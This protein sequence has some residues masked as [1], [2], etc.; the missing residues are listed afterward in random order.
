M[1][2][3][4][5]NCRF[6]K[7]EKHMGSIQ[8]FYR[9]YSRARTPG[10]RKRSMLHRPTSRVSCFVSARAMVSSARDWSANF[11]SALSAVSWAPRPGR[12]HL[13]CFKVFCIELRLVLR[14]LLV[15][16]WP[17]AVLTSTWPHGCPTHVG[18]QWGR[19]GG[20][21]TKPSNASGE[22]P[23]N[24]RKTSLTSS[25]ACGTAAKRT[26]GARWGEGQ[27]WAPHVA[28]SGRILG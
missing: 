13:R 22:R 18:Q 24:D 3:Q 11:K 2:I 25:P 19:T 27:N 14:R 23:Q 21:K 20:A 7:N 1:T 6:P 5:L 17:R 9:G 4:R 10:L 28:E 26:S 12:G 15:R 8:P 16:S